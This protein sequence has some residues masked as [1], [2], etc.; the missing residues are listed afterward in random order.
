MFSGQP[1]ARVRGPGARGD[2]GGVAPRQAGE[3][4]VVSEWSRLITR[5]EHCSLI[6]WARE[7]NGP[8]NINTV[9]FI[10]LYALLF[11]VYLCFLLIYKSFCTF[12]LL[13]TPWWWTQDKGCRDLT[14]GLCQA[15]CRVPQGG[16][17]DLQ[18]SIRDQYF[19]LKL[20][21]CGSKYRIYI[22]SHSYGK[23]MA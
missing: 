17:Q 2:H 23:K 16:L 22:G 3:K 12:R 7:Q 6:S 10:S 5:P 14:M 8:L 1:S 13:E 15:R 11:T 20:S 4:V 18:I 9:T 21:N 19:V